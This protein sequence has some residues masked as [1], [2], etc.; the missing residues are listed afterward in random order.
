[1]LCAACKKI[2][3][4]SLNQPH[5]ILHGHYVHHE[6]ALTIEATGK[7]GCY[8]CVTLW[9][10]FTEDERELIRSSTDDKARSVSFLQKLQNMF[11]ATCWR[12]LW[13]ICSLVVGPWAKQSCRPND[14]CCYGWRPNLNRGSVDF[15]FGTT[16]WKSIFFALLPCSGQ[17]F[18]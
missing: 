11:E 10:R 16:R 1:M 18:L 2:F 4:S 12:L 15:S 14:Y 13:P 6:S 5:P 8:I 7:A 17:S 9:D 3:D